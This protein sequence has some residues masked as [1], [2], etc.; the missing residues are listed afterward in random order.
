M[1]TISKNIFWSLLTSTLQIYTGSVVFIFLAKAMTVDNFGILS[2][3]FSLSTLAVI[4]A[5][6][7]FSLMVIKDYPVEIFNL[8]TYI[9]NS[10]LAKLLIGI[11]SS[12]LFFLYILNFYRGDWLSVG[13]M[14]IIFALISSFTV[15]LQA[16]FRTQNRFHKFAESNIIYAAGVTITILIYWKF[17]IG[18]LSL[19]GIL[20]LSKLTQFLWTLYLCKSLF[21]IYTFNIKLIKK[22]IKNSWSFG[23]HSVLGIFYFMVDTQI[24][25]LYLGSKEV[26]LY[27]S[28]FRVI[29]ILLLFGELISNVLLPYL[30][31]KFYNKEN[32]SD[33]LSK[34]FLYLLIIGC[35][36]F[37]FFTTFD[38]QLLMLLY[39]R[40]YLPA[41]ILILP[42]SIVVV[43]RTTSSLLGNVLTISNRQVN[44]VTTVG[45]SLIVSLILNLILIPK[46]GIV[47]A[48]WTSVLV[49]LLLFG[50]YFA[51]C[52]L[53][54]PSIKLH[55]FENICLLISTSFIYFIIQLWNPN[56]N[57][58]VISICILAW[59]MFVYFIMKKPIKG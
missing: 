8:K 42:L 12:L 38:R 26:A 22:L 35:S 50:M 33:L 40:E 32:V 15:Y 53:E 16:L 4:M 24:I 47:A 11:G 13:T 7:G 51:F 31:F 58:W 1:P 49:H 28:V 43:I 39:N 14:Y 17:Q 59:I 52:K 9:T 27:Q 41:D 21:N 45:I 19:V 46:Y 10:V 6:F 18:L 29:L 56:N 2:F 34:I 3:G 20:L 37:L 48:A 30:S 25:A 23:L 44:R 5:D 36:L 57:Y 54:V 55:S